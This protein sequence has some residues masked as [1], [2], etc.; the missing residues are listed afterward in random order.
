[1]TS[2]ALQLEASHSLSDRDR[3]STAMEMGLKEHIFGTTQKKFQNIWQTM[4]E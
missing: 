4:R 2:E 1:M 3:A